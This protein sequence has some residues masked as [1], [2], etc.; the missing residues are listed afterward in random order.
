VVGSASEQRIALVVAVAVV[1]S[2]VLAAAGT[3][4]FLI[5]ARTP[6]LDS[7]S[8]SASLTG[9]SIVISGVSRNNGAGVAHNV[10]VNA[11]VDLSGTG[12]LAQGDG[13]RSVN[14][15]DLAA[16]ASKPYSV[17]IPVGDRNLGAGVRY[18]AAPSWD[19]PSLD[20][21]ELSFSVTYSGSHVIDN[22]TGK[23]KNSGK[24]PAPNVSITFTESADK[25]GQSVLGATTTKLGDVDASGEAP[26]KLAV[27]IGPNPPN[28]LYYGSTFSYDSAQVVDEQETER[29]VGG[30]LRMTGFVRNGGAVQAGRLVLSASLLNS[31]GTELASGAA[32]VGTLVPG[33]R[34]PFS[35]TIDLGSSAAGDARWVRV[36]VAW[37]QTRFLILR[38]SKSQSTREPVPVS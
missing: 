7:E 20:V 36:T 12:P 24:G 9:G 11:T 17:S 26:F 29:R 32:K 16:G 18:K 35:L 1:S 8:E 33:A 2:I 25:A 22:V 28:D 19:R 27:D 13:V 10:V 6:R 3:A 14:L 15:G 5:G 34:A 30:T 21:A 4:G 37:E 23:V 31:F 38:E